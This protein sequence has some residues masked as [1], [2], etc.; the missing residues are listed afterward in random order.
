[1]YKAILLIALLS[2][3]ACSPDE[4]DEQNSVNVTIDHEPT[5]AWGN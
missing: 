2:L 3:F 5:D 4:P 1:M